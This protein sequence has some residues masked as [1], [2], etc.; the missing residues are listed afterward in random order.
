MNIVFFG[1]ADFGCNTLVDLIESEH[2]LVGVVTN[3][4][5][6]SGRSQNYIS[7]PIKKTALEYNTFLLEVDNIQDKGFVD[8]LNS[9]NADLFIV[10]AYK[11]LPQ[12][13]YSLPKYGSINIHASLLPQYKGPSPIQQA[14][15]N[16]DN[17]TGLSSFFINKSIDGG[18]LIFQ[19]EIDILNSDDFGSLWKKLSDL[20]ASFTKKTI[21]LISS[22]K[23]ELINKKISESY[24]PKISKDQLRVNWEEDAIKIHN[25]VRAFSP[26]PCMFSL[27][28]KKRIKIFKTKPLKILPEKQFESGQFFIDNNQIVVKCGE[29][30]LEIL[31]L[32]PESKKRLSASEFLNGHLSSIEKYKFEN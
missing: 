21:D 29:D 3:K 4:D 8:R 9:L 28:N 19:K 17:Q 6:K 25:Q 14:L 32:Q 27:L 30:F 12:M 18:S 15:I 7:T 24:A 11:I 2:N 16:G 13:I 20:S 22:N 5:A 10:I 1:N 31:E 23:K 26:Y